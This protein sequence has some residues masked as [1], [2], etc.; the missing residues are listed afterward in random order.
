MNSLE[1]LF[2]LR[3]HVALVTGASSGI[4]VEC[5]IALAIAGADVAI[6]ARR[7]EPL[8]RL[9]EKLRGLNVRAIAIAADITDSQALER[10]MA[11]SVAELG[12]IDILVNNAGMSTVAAAERF[13]LADWEATFKLNVTA[14]MMLA[15]KVAHRLIERKQPGRIINVTSIYSAL[16]GPYRRPLRPYRMAA[17]AASK[18]A[19]A[20]LTRQLA[21]EWAEYGIN[22]NA[23]APGM[24]PTELNQR[25]LVLA[26]I[27]ERTEAFTPMGRLG[28]VEEVRG[29][30]IFLA[31]AA[32]SFMT[33]ASVAVDGGYTA[34]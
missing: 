5:A 24:I 30:I 27:R 33:G 7:R 8:E 16:A 25:A 29:A 13:P 15:Q 14:A 1:A 19:L 2:S 3:G 22:V 17:Y 4:G 9:A 26:G 32:S 20:N 10:V 28:S 21:V 6:V 12:E 18:G 23:L 34:W 11:Q 31:S